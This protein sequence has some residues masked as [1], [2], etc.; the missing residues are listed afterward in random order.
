MYSTERIANYSRYRG[1]IEVKQDVS[2]QYL[3]TP[4]DGHREGGASV[5]SYSSQMYSAWK[6]FLATSQPYTCMWTLSYMN[7]YSDRK[8]VDA[9]WHCAKHINRSIW[10]P[11][12]S[13]KGKGIHAT[14]VAERHKVSCELRGRLHFHILMQKLDIDMNDERFTAIVNDAALWLRDDF[15]NP[16]SDSSRINVQKVYDA[17]G[18]AQ[19]LTKDLQTTHWPKGDNVFFVRPKGLE[20][21]VFRLKGSVELN[22]CH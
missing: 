9:L 16:M 8:A 11:R 14:V 22:M 13:K 1:A 17:S 5:N 10:G 12:W 6:E 19:Y 21:I 2:P 3:G 20:G 18:L 7:P 4:F 15:N